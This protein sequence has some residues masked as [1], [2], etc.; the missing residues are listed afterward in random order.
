MFNAALKASFSL[1]QIHTYL[2]MFETWH[3]YM[4][5]F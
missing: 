5:T 2:C 4:E 1:K 3:D